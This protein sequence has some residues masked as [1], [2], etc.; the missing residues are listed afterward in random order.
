MMWGMLCDE[1]RA[2]PHAT[3]NV[4]PCELLLKRKLRTRFD[5]MIPNT[6]QH[7]TSKQADQKQRHD[8]HSRSQ[9]MFPGTTVLVREYNYPEWIPD[10]ILQR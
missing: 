10:V 2:T 4:S 6:K 1:Y 9:P 5:L 7:V 3:T 8:K